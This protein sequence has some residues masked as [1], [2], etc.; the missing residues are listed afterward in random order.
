MP[1]WLVDDAGVVD[2]LLGVLA[3]ALAAGWWFTRKR[4]YLV[5]VGVVVL[6]VLAVWLLGRFAETDAKQ[7]KGKLEA[8]AAGVEENNLD[9]TFQH[10][11]EKFRLQG[12]LTK[13]AFRQR[14]RG[15]IDSGEVQ[16]V[17]VWDVDVRDI[18]RD[19]KTATVHFMAK[20]EGTVFGAGGQFFKCRAT[21]MLDPDGQ[22]RLQD[23]QVFYPAT[24]PATGESI[25]LPL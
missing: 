25:H 17:K 13:D 11:S 9:K 4:G 8:M 12:H 10:I 16:R 7:I 18:D 14:G 19:K 21:F 2:V 20:P 24:D 5:G 6:L 22:W 1:S 23:F 15:L 3:L